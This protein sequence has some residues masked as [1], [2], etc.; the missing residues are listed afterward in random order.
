MILICEANYLTGLRKRKFFCFA[1]LLTQE[2]RKRFFPPIPP[3]AGRQAGKNSF[4]PHPFFFLPACWKPPAIF[5]DG[6]GTSNWA[7]GE[8]SYFAFLKRLLFVPAIL[9][10]PFRV[11]A[12]SISSHPSGCPIPPPPIIFFS[13]RSVQNKA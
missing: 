1:F 12:P 10:L 8:V 6:G 3:S 4:S 11:Y 9:F 7:V 2:L 5:S 13:P